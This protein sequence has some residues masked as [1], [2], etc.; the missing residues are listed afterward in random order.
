MRVSASRIGREQT[1]VAIIDDAVADPRQAVE[2]AAALAP[3]PPID[4]NY[5]PGQRRMIRRDEP[6]HA[7]TA[8]VCNAVAQVMFD[9]FGVG[10]FH[11]KESSFSIVTQTPETTQLIQRVPHFDTVDPT[12]YAVLHYLT[13]PPQGGTAFYRHRR[14]GYERLTQPRYDAYLAALDQDLAEFGP[15]AP[16]YITQSSPAFEQIGRCDGLF[17]RIVIYQGALLHCAEIAPGFAFDTDPRKGRL[18]GNI[19]IRA[20]PP[21]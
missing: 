17:N 8:T 15:P 1:P 18:T 4:R 14:T 2:M 16:A 3:F 7:Y 11:V 21:G 9:V 10:R 20:L 6:A 5:Y 13:E 19:F 12:D